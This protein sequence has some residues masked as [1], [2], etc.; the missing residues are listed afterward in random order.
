MMRDEPFGEVNPVRSPC[1][2]ELAW[3]S[4][5]L[6][7]GTECAGG[8]V[9]RCVRELGEL[10]QRTRCTVRSLPGLDVSQEGSPTARIICLVHGPF[11]S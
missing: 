2:R 8:R 4:W 9:I 5:T 7:A 11:P 6:R 1:G 10:P 3:T